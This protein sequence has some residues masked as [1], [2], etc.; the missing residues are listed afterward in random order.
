MIE[1]ARALAPLVESEADAAEAGGRMTAPVVEALTGAGLFALMVPAA[2]GGTEADLVTALEVLEEVCRAD[3]ST[4][5]SLLANVTSS[6]FAGAYCS[7]D[8]VKAMW[9]GELPPVHAGQ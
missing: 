7:D 3:G 8:A 9:S 5:W 6:A 1:A 4:G 2:L